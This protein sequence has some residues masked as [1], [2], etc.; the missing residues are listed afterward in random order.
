MKRTLKCLKFDL[1]KFIYLFIDFILFIYLY[2]FMDDRNLV[3]CQILSFLKYN[4]MFYWNN[5]FLYKLFIR[6]YFYCVLD[7]IS[8]LLLYKAVFNIQLILLKIIGHRCWNPIGFSGVPTQTP[9]HRPIPP[10][11][12]IKLPSQSPRKLP[13]TFKPPCN[14]CCHPCLCDGTPSIDSLIKSRKLWLVKYWR[15]QKQQ[16]KATQMNTEK[17]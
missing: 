7:P 17:T 8:K 10:L 5:I 15:Q 1:L 13:P 4:N 2:F 9:P 14:C 6:Y 3:R 16:Q 12:P 11:I